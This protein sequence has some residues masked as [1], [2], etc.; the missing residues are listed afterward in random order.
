MRRLTSRT[1]LAATAVALGSASVA[2]APAD[3]APM[4]GHWPQRAITVVDHT[5]DAGWQRAEAEAVE[6]WNAANPH[7]RLAFR[8]G[9][10]GACRS[11]ASTI[12][13]CV[14]DLGRRRYQGV[15]YVGTSGGHIT[16]AHVEFDDRAFSDA[17]KTSLACHELGHAIG[18]PHSPRRSSCLSSRG[19]APRPDGR[20]AAMLTAAYGHSE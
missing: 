14:R 19:Y 2:M 4:V 17:Q 11:E 12:G 15:T 7:L 16:D 10:P 5:G 6:A 20:D 9:T 8:V 3:A 18:M 13:V 1:A